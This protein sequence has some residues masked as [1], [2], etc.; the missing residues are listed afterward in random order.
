MLGRH[1]SVVVR[2]DL[3]SGL[4][5]FGNI[6]WFFF[7][8]FRTTWWLCISEVVCLWCCL[9]LE[10]KPFPTLRVVLL[11]TTH[12]SDLLKSLLSQSSTLC[13]FM[14]SVDWVGLGWTTAEVKPVYRMFSGLSNHLSTCKCKS[15]IQ[16]D[17]TKQTPTTSGSYLLSVKLGRKGVKVYI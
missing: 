13:T 9:P 14:T 10:P 4:S 1:K 6:P 5:C 2:L 11:A 16:F 8:F 3:M 15:H 7:A 17:T 12:Q